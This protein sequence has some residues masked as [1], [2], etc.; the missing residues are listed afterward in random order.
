[1]FIKICCISSKQE[2]ELAISLGTSAIGL[3]SEMPSGP[4][5]ISE[6]LISEIAGSVPK[7]IRT[8]LLTSKRDVGE[9]V[10]QHK[11]CMTNTIQLVDT[12]ETGTYEELKSA[13]PGV[14]LVQVVHITDE[15]S[16]KQA[17]DLKNEVDAILLD[18]G[19]ADL[20]IKILGGTGNTHNWDISREIVKSVKLPV[21]LAG[22]LNPEN[23]REAIEVVQPAG[24][25]VCSGV[26]SKGRLDK[27]KLRNFITAVRQQ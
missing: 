24:V 6:E 18:S 16:I 17:V 26:R 13:L 20:R 22:G 25:D 27:S 23:V 15:K 5:V 10:R 12:L 8:F 11:K 2:A 9:V 14:S 21:Y 3:V 7:R 1:M 19:N 4:G